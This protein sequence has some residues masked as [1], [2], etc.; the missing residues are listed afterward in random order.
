MARGTVGGAELARGTS[1]KHGSI[2]YNIYD[3]REKD[4]DRGRNTTPTTS[5]LS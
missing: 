4:T 2:E 5:N 1:S 3:G